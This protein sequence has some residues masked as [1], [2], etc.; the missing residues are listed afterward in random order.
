[1]DLSV[2]WK[3]SYG[4]Y[5]ISA[6]EEQRPTG[7]IVNTVSQITSNEPIIISVSINKENYT[8]GVI[9]K[10][11][12]FGI[13]ILS[14]QTPAAVIG[15]LGYTSGK[16]TDK[17]AGIGY[18]II[19]GLPLVEA[20]CSGYLLCEVQ[21]V[22]D[23]GT[24]GIVLATVAD[25]CSGVDIKP[26]TYRYFHDVIKGKAPKNAPTYQAEKTQPT[27]RYT[28]KICGYVY[29]GDIAEEAE[30]YLCPICSAPKTLFEKSRL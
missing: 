8:Y 7:C 23:C 15:T 10:T 5:A 28:C 22:I 4:M 26:M 13:S 3:L 6:M 25:S 1:M 30:D 18:R 21:N 24:H 27:I 2:L 11:K 9:E 17:F 12:R 20:N 16:D 14:E 29:E 19:N